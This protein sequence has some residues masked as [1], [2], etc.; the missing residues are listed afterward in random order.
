M[1]QQRKI[2]LYYY[3]LHW[4]GVVRVFIVG[5][6]Q[7]AVVCCSLLPSKAWAIFTAIY[8]CK[9]LLYIPISEM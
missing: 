2:I 7:G 4:M 6:R 8:L 1:Q 5:R 3:S 9:E